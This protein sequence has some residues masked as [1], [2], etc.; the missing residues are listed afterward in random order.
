MEY[1]IP[2]KED[3]KIGYQCEFLDVNQD[4]WFNKI[5]NINNNQK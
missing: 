4:I 3:I 2:T 1:F 5:I